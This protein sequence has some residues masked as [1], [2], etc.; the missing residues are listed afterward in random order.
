MIGAF[1][2]HE[3]PRVAADE[4]RVVEALR[5]H[6]PAFSLDRLA[7]EARSIVGH[8][9][10]IEPRRRTLT[11]LG[12]ADVGRRG[13]LTTLRFGD[14]VGAVECDAELAL[15]LVSALAGGRSLPRI[16][17]SPRVSPEVAGALGGVV[18][19]LLRHAGLEDLALDRVDASSADLVDG[20]GGADARVLALDLGARIG[21]LR[22]GVRVLIAAKLH[23]PPL[24][25]VRGNAL[26]HRLGTTELRLPVVIGAAWAEARVFADLQPGDVVVLD[27]AKHDE[28]RATLAAPHAT[29]GVPL[30]LLAADGPARRAR[31]GA[32]QVPLA[33][34]E[35]E[36]QEARSMGA[37]EDDKADATGATM[38][39]AALD[40]GAP[41]AA[42]LGEVPVLVR[43]E[44]GAVTMPAHRWAS[45][46][47]GDVLVLDGRVGDA[48]VLRIGGH[49]VGR[50]ELVDVDGALGVRLLEKRK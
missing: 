49:V 24:P 27:G 18:L 17:R 40:E 22:S 5:A 42:A 3:L 4:P 30:T 44:A 10:A 25:L 20:F 45:V 34:D 46:G 32:G 50:G 35:K 26:L 16:A 31:L 48:V 29:H 6:A 47:V 13:A 43:V 2:W 19:H 14:V 1:P 39:L 15:A 12:K 9:V 41:L 36:R 23:G 38:Q 33:A 37:N 11:T 21:M 7:A 28:P 8:E